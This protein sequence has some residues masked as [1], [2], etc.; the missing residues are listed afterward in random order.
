MNLPTNFKVQRDGI[1][2]FSA[3]DNTPGHPDF[4]CREFVGFASPIIGSAY[5]YLYFEDAARRIAQYGF[6]TTILQAGVEY[7]I[8][9]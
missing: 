2:I 3:A 9:A 7:Q 4:P 8:A 5:T 1:E 6:V